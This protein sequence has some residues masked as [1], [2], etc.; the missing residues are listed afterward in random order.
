MG[1]RYPEA[2]CG[3]AD[4]PAGRDQGL[5]DESALELA[6]GVLKARRRGVGAG[7]DRL[8][9]EEVVGLDGVGLGSDGA[10]ERRLG[11]VG[12]LAHV[13]GPAREGRHADGDGAQRQRRQTVACGGA[14]H[15]AVQQRRD[16]AAALVEARDADRHD[17]EAVVEVGPE[18]AV[19]DALVEVDVGRRDD[20]DVGGAGLGGAERVVD[21]VLEELQE[22][23]LG[24]GGELADLVE[25]ERAA[26][27][28]LDLARA[29][30]GG[31]RVGARLGA[32]E[33]ALD[34][35]LGQRGAVQL[36]VGPLGAAAVLGDEARDQG[37]AGA[38]GAG[39]EHVDVERGD[40]AELAQ[41][42]GRGVAAADQ[43]V[44]G[45]ARAEGRRRIGVLADLGGGDGGR[46][47][48]REELGEVPH[49]GVEAG[50]P[51]PVEIEHPERV[52]DADGDAQ[53]GADAA[54]LDALAVLK[55][56]IGACR[57]GLEG[58]AAR[59]RGRDNAP[60][61]K[62][63]N[64]C[65]VGVACLVGDPP[66]RL[67]AAGVV[68]APDFDVALIRLGDVQHQLKRVAQ[69]LL[70]VWGV[71]Q[72][73]QPDQEVALLVAANGGVVGMCHGSV[74]PKTRRSDSRGD[75]MMRH[76]GLALV[77][78]VAVA[79][80][81]AGCEGPQGPSGAQGEPGVAGQ[82]GADGTT[83]AQ[84]AE[85]ARGPAGTAGERGETGASGLPGR[86]GAP[87]AKGDAGE[88]GQ[89]GAQGD[90]GQDGA[91]AGKP[92]LFFASISG[93]EG[94]AFIGEPRVIDLDITQG[95]VAPEALS[96]TAVSSGGPIIRKIPGTLS[97]Q[98]EWAAEDEE[99]DAEGDFGYL[100]AATDGCVLAIGSFELKVARFRTY[101]SVVNLSSIH[102]PQL[103]AVPAGGGESYFGAVPYEA[104]TGFV[105]LDHGDVAIDLMTDGWAVAAV[106]TPAQPLEHD[107]R[108]TLVVMDLGGGTATAFIEDNVDPV[109][110][111]DLARALIFHAA[112]GFGAIS[113]ASPF[114]PIPMM[115]G[116][117][118]G[119]RSESD[120]IL[121]NV[122]P[123]P[124][125]VSVDGG[126]YAGAVAPAENTVE[127]SF[128]YAKG[129]AL[130]A[131][132]R[133]FGLT[134]DSP[135]VT[136]EV[137]ELS[138]EN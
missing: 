23:G 128:F 8:V 100:V 37:L 21:A 38:G 17:C 77:L 104:A 13:T 67:G 137:V 53:D 117:P 96:I 126:D 9:G 132:I 102:A 45:E 30:A 22:L 103:D 108:Y 107:T 82:P 15:D 105:E 84:G 35:G 62:C 98:V 32:E 2:A 127:T 16:V 90:P 80:F 73:Q 5:L 25:E 50:A 101:L 3:L 48:A 78:G 93:A 60:R 68:I 47:V 33:L 19:G 116:I 88:A 56:R 83:G 40:E 69:H 89:P 94:I 123:I 61:D 99:P 121:T 118:Y 95:G 135:G 43:R 14:G 113:V 52:R 34:E 129:D 66:A 18:A 26:V 111:A 63:A 114:G 112:D 86:D 97:L 42:G 58:L 130:F 55:A 119:A 136:Y 75:K 85:G 20:P 72:L 64:P 76:I 122:G 41:D 71:P 36:D 7:L 65:D 57:G 12:E 81:A 54:G 134:L 110:E 115:Q 79:L 44:D 24:A 109:T 10:D 125:V 28:R 11:R 120:T 124:I 106:A 39:Q 87:G 59:E 4:V 49:L 6:G 1:A 131:L 138:K 51:V 31:G 92:P 27:C 70:D 91:C 133:G 74:V 29:G 46:G